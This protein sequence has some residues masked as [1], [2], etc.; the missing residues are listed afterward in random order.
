M[1]EIKIGRITYQIEPKDYILDNGVHKMFC[2][3]DGRTLLREGFNRYNYIVI[4][5]SVL[6]KIDFNALKKV[7]KSENCIYYYFQ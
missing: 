2:A 7:I 5:K 4:P 3:G 1:K 6:K